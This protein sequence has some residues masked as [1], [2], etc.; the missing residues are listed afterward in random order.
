MPSDIT[1]AD[2]FRSSFSVSRETSKLLEAYVDLLLKWN[3][4]I[5]LVSKSTIDEIWHRHIAD[6]AQ[7][8]GLVK[9]S[10]SRKWVDLG[11]G[12]GFPGLVVAA[13]SKEKSPNT[14]FELIESDNRKCAFLRTVTRE[15]DLNVMIMEGRVESF[16]PREADMISARAF[17][18]LTELLGHAS[19]HGKTGVKCL[20]MKG[21]SYDDELTVAQKNWNID[22]EVIPS[23]TDSSAC[24]LK[25]KDIS[26]AN[27]E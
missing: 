20:F 5:N 6:S 7:L 8:F 3:R 2:E 10:A 4:S 11:S 24:I 21:Q 16:A 26:R 25:I 13:L 17:T 23:M 15:L 14:K 9:P 22:V 18:G 19:L 1:N 27:E 12:G